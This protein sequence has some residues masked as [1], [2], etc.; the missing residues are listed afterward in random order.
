MSRYEGNVDWTDYHPV[1][2]PDAYALLENGE[3][4]DFVELSDE[5]VRSVDTVPELPAAAQEPGNGQ[6]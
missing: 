3:R 6:A 2:G 5:A 4:I 1:Y